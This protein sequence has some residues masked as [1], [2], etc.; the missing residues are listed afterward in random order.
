MSLQVLLAGILGA[1]LGWYAGE[2]LRWV[3]RKARERI[4]EK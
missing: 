4:G 3:Y 1:V 2:G